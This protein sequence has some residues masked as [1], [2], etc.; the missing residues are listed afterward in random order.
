MVSWASRHT[1]QTLLPP[2]PTCMSSK[3]TYSLASPLPC[4]PSCPSYPCSPLGPML[5]EGDF[6]SFL[7]PSLVASPPPPHTHTQVSEVKMSLQSCQS[8]C[9]PSHVDPGEGA[10]STVARIKSFQKHQRQEAL[11]ITLT[12]PLMSPCLQAMA[13]HSSSEVVP[14]VPEGPAGQCFFPFHS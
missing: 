8:L 13:Q 11:D 4:P 14:P 7:G 12:D 5:D 1:T 2:H 10:C 6:T 3:Q 9:M